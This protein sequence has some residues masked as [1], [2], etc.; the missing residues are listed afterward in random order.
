MRRSYVWLGLVIILF[1]CVCALTF[2][3][4]ITGFDQNV[5]AAV[6]GWETPGLTRLMEGF[7]WIGSTI[8]ATL[9]S[10]VA[11]LFL[12]FVLGHRKELIFFVAVVGGSAL[13]NKVL[14]NTF[15]RE[16]PN[17]HRLVE[18]TGYSFPSGHSMA[19]FAL[20]GALIYL[21][22]RHVRSGAGK[23]VLVVIG[24]LLILC[25]G[26]SRIYLGVHYPSDVI[27]GYLASSVWLGLMI[28]FFRKWNQRLIK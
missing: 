7:S 4:H 1:A 20:Y 14:K 16:R 21:L 13:L 3:D 12:A 10:A 5:I 11:F 18:E 24:S 15:H 2:T 8:G 27:G 17:L 19:A 6:Q 23:I 25:I 28:E 9:I 22:W 26:L